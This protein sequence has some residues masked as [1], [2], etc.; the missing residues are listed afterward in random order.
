[1]TDVV[2]AQV[3]EEPAHPA[4]LAPSGGAAL[5]VTPDIGAADLVARLG[6]IEEAMRTAMKPDLDYGIIP[7]SKKPS[8]FKPGAEKL[9][10][11]FRLDIQFENEKVWDGSH[12]TVISKAIVNDAPTRIRLGGGEGICS[13]REKKYAYR[14]ANLACPRCGEETVFKSKHPPRDDPDAPPGWFCW[15]AKGG[16]GANFAADAAEI[17]TQERGTVANPDLPDMWNTVLK[18]AKKRAMVDGVLLVTGASALFTQD[19][20]DQE[21]NEAPPVNTQPPADRPSREPSGP[22]PSL[23]KLK[24]EMERYEFADDVVAEVKAYIQ[25]EAGKPNLDRVDELLRHFAR[26]DVPRV[27]RAAGVE[28]S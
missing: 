24:S 8:L 27:L 9:S 25:D 18:M 20:E 26:Q 19:L 21:Q 11:L 10:V 2:D 6:V 15:A 1:M 4:A 16:C 3:V 7:G 12:L 14:I 5:T 22:A 13:T 17:V 23:L 28:A